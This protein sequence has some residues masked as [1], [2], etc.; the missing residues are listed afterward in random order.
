[1]DEL[2]NNYNNY[3]PLMHNLIHM[4]KDNKVYTIKVPYNN[5]FELFYIQYQLKMQ[6]HFTYT[7]TDKKAVTIY[8]DNKVPHEDAPNA[9]TVVFRMFHEYAT[10][11]AIDT[12]DLPDELLA[13]EY[14]GTSGSAKIKRL[15]FNLFITCSNIFL[16]F[17]ILFAMIQPKVFKLAYAYPGLTFIFLAGLYTWIIVLNYRIAPKYTMSWYV[18]RRYMFRMSHWL[19]YFGLSDLIM[20]A[21]IASLGVNIFAVCTFDVIYNV[22]L[23]YLLV[24]ATIFMIRQVRYT[25]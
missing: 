13:N 14:Y 22:I 10:T 9:I 2:R 1:M 12:T 18:P 4:A 11:Y 23:I 17:G 7:T 3:S 16:C 25:L 20:V 8:L 15:L 24:V 19:L 6:M 21:I 5:L